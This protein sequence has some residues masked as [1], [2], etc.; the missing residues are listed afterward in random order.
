[1]K[2]YLKKEKTII[3]ILIVTFI[4]RI[5]WICTIK[6]YPVSD[7]KLIYDTGQ[8]VA[9][10]NFTGF[11]G[12]NY[13]ERFPHDSITVLYFALLFKISKYPLFLLKFLNCIYGTA[14]VYL[15]YKIGIR[16]YNKKLGVI[17][18]ILLTCFPPFII[19]TAE[20]MA[21]NMA[22]PL[23]LYSILL[24]IRFVQED[25]S[26]ILILSGIFLGLG[27]L[28]RPVG[29]VVIIAYII[30]Y[31]ANVFLYKRGKIKTSIIKIVILIITFILPTIC[32]SNILV[33]KKILENQLWN[34][35]EPTIVTVLIGTNFNTIGAWNKEDSAIPKDYDYNKVLI[36]KA[37]R[38]K[39][40]RRF[41]NHT[42]LEI[43]KFYGEKIGLQWGIGD[44]GA[45]GW[46]INNNEPI[47]A[48]DNFAIVMTV[49]S[50]IYYLILLIFSIIG[51]K[52]LKNKFNLEILF[53]IIILLG[54][55]G[56]YMITERQS[57]Y[58]FV[59][60]WIFPILAAWGIVDRVR[61]EF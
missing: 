12:H 37:S 23:F 22:I 34:P 61:I 1:M 41:K 30:Y 45:C 58:A 53:F 36:E 51:I 29:E 38:E 56:F 3:Y 10:G 40:I 17:T 32:I 14:S 27:D 25:N 47:V 43:I 20:A 46:V 28:F 24:F 6:A 49:I 48:T 21:E 4:L 8:K 52:N 35:G 44:F 42:P 9:S 39:I 19:Y 18:A 5:I 15:I 11:Y 13:F 59:I 16:I 60:A 33:N 7:F 50:W 57:R 54:F 55:I 26:L 2:K 31:L